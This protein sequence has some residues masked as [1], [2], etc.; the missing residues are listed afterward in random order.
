MFQPTPV[1]KLQPHI[2]NSTKHSLDPYYVPDP[3]ISCL[4]VLTL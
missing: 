1:P 3:V 2:D 4:C